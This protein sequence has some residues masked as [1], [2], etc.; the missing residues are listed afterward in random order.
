M[1]QPTGVSAPASPPQQKDFLYVIST[2][3]KPGLSLLRLRA[4]GPCFLCPVAVCS[5][6]RD[7]LTSLALPAPQVFGV[8]TQRSLPEPIGPDAHASRRGFGAG[9]PTS[10]GPEDSSPDERGLTPSFNVDA[11]HVKNAP[12]LLFPSLVFFACAGLRLVILV[13]QLVN[14][15][16]ITI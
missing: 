12:P 11:F 6:L 3:S 16:C 10:S 14:C 5:R 13:C 15:C 2:T 9:A 7:I 4:S 8:L 1:L